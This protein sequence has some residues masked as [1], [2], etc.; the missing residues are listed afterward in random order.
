MKIL[1]LRGQVPKDRN[2]NEILFDE[3]GNSDDIYTTMVHRMT[4]P[5]E[6]SEVWYWDRPKGFREKWK[7]EKITVR[8]GIPSTFKVFDIVWS[9]GGF[10]EQSR[11]ISEYFMDMPKVYYGAGPRYCPNDGIKYDLILADSTEQKKRIEKKQPK[12]RVELWIKPAPEFFAPISCEKEYDI[13]YIANKEQAERKG[14]KWVYKTKPDD[15]SML[16]LGFGYKRVLRCEMPAQISKCKVGILP[17][18]KIDSCPRAM[19]EMVA[20]GIPVVALD[21]VRFWYTKYWPV[22]V[23]TKENFW[24]AVKWSMKTENNSEYAKN[25]LTLEKASIYLNDLFKGLKC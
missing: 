6:H 8:Y 3:I 4:E 14:V 1:L 2:P 22:T 17:Y 7:D 19:T 23:T 13:C 5:G 18:D 11:L 9:R 20:C 15:L 10:K 16:H 21:T 12:S 24:A 25:N